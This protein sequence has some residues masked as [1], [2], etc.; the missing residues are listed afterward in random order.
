MSASNPILVAIRPQHRR[1]EQLLGK[2][3]YAFVKSFRSLLLQAGFE[4][5]FSSEDLFL[6]M[7]S[8]VNSAFTAIFENLDSVK[9]EFEWQEIHGAVPLQIVLH[10][11]NKGETGP[12][13]A[14]VDSEIWAFLDQ[15]TPYVSKSLKQ[16][17]DQ[18]TTTRVP[19][20]SFADVDHG[21]YR[22]DIENR[23]LIKTERLFPFRKLSVSSGNKRE[24]FYCGM[25]NHLPSNCPSKLLTMEL[26]GLDKIGYL[27]FKKLGKSF[28]ETFTNLRPVL[29]RL[30]AGPDNSRIRKDPH[31]LSFVAYLDLYKIFQFRFLHRISFSVTTKWENI[32][33]RDEMHIEDN[34]LFI[35]L[36]CLR[37][38]QYE[39]AEKSLLVA[40]GYKQE[41]Q[42]YAFIGLAFLALERG[43]MQ[44]MGNCFDQALS[45]AEQNKEQMY[46]NL[47][48]SRYY[49]LVDNLWKAQYA[50]KNILK[51]DP[52]NHEGRYR[53][54]QIEIKSGFSEKSFRELQLLQKHSKEFFMTLLMD[55]QLQ[56]VHGFIDEMLSERIKIMKTSAT[57]LLTKASIDCEDLKSWFVEDDERLKSCLES[58][59]SL[60]ERLQHDTC[61]DL[62]DVMDKGEDLRDR[63][64]EIRDACLDELDSF[65]KGALKKHQYYE[66]FWRMFPYKSFFGND[67][68]M[69][70]RLHAKLAEIDR[71]VKEGA[72]ESYRKAL[73]ISVKVIKLL[74]KIKRAH[75]RQVMVDGFMG[76]A[77]SF[78]KKLVFSEICVSLV[79][80]LVFSVFR[81]ELS[82][83]F[84]M[85]RD[86]GLY[87]KMNV[88]G[89]AVVAPLIAI[90]LTLYE[91]KE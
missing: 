32:F 75:T 19:G 11:F 7:F 43:R 57:T 41:K 65:V 22:V 15:E 35:G 1:G 74:Q 13:V 9:V 53:F 27:S 42:F 70:L 88:L 23:E 56:P 44:E 79:V 55:P 61:Y 73:E 89:L 71:L 12:M 72:G 54:I 48:L 66:K 36:D 39:K 18:F 3:W 34:N 62:F 28:R 82:Q 10:L 68:K 40:A 49:D 69:L 84:G 81:G 8:S 24:C 37:T 33:S 21:L 14:E 25:R 90:S 26:Q 31:L 58:L 45:L 63:C 50:V 5:Q 16:Q 51:I 52:E 76:K 47:L 67:K 64:D 29:N 77:L 4:N 87:G 30:A 80:Y 78:A 6:F 38:G 60:Q 20:C 91:M 46:I 2:Q 59:D 85:F 86:P 83:I 17:W